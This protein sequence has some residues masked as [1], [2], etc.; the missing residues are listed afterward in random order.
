[1]VTQT[2]Q[3]GTSLV[4]VAESYATTVWR[5]LC[6]D[7]SGPPIWIQRRLVPDDSF[8]RLALVTFTKTAPLSYRSLS[9]PRS[10]PTS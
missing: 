7:A 8:N 1:M 3:E 5:Q 4:N 9:G 10:L 2:E 6:P